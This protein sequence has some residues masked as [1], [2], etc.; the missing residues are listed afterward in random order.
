MSGVIATKTN[1]A[2]APLTV[3]DL[4]AYME[5][6]NKPA[7]AWRIGTEHEKFLYHKDTRAPVTYESPDGKDI[8]TLLQV[9]ADRHAWTLVK[10]GEMIVGVTKG[11]YSINLETGGQIELSGAP[12]PD[13]H[14]V[15]RELH[16]YLDEVRKICADL[17]IGIMG[18]GLNPKMSEKDITILPRPRYQAM[19]QDE[20]TAGGQRWGLLT[21]AVQC[22][23]DYASES[24]MI[25]KFRVSLALQPITT[26]L[27]A[28]SPFYAGRPSGLLSQ[29][30]HFIH[31]DKHKTQRQVLEAAFDPGF[32]FRSYVNFIMNQP[33][34]MFVRDGQY[35]TPK[36]GSFGD[37]M[38]G[39]L[40][41]F[42]GQHATHTDFLAHI[43]TIHTDVRLRN[44]IEQ[45]G[46]DGGQSRLLVAMPAL[47]TGLL[48]DSVALDEAYQ[49]IK[50]WTV[51][52]MMYLRDH[53][54]RSGLRTRFKVFNSVRG[55]ALEM[56]KIAYRGLRNRTVK[57]D[58]SEDETMYLDRLMY[59]VATGRTP[60]E[61]L[62]DSYHHRWSQN[63]DR[64]MQECSF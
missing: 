43:S 44:Y 21:A 56:I 28:N 24:D 17:D 40:G 49:M 2:E 34:K 36:A 14:L 42:E 45:R 50:N 31:S 25:K 7:D 64:V 54:S 23:M 47:W 61:Y 27:F 57:N 11:K 6:G 59:F 46:A 52:D 19:F 38:Q 18:I 30:Y 15:A 60:A 58:Y 63:I 5:A 53:V 37:L 13:M 4:L 26:A 32:N 12:L 55:I 10:E 9:L 20:T 29:R 48:Y 1:E 51:N 33:M 41:G 62:L 3:N 22:N 16:T 35:V 39:R 8:K